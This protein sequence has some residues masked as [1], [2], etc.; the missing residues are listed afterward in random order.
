MASQSSNSRKGDKKIKEAVFE[1][2]DS[3]I[4][5]KTLQEYSEIITVGTTVE[6][7]KAPSRP[8][9]K[10]NVPEVKNSNATFVYNYF[11]RDERVRDESP[12]DLDRIIILDSSNSEEIFHRSKN[13]KLARYVKLKFSPPQVP[14]SL[15]EAINPQNNSGIDLSEQLSKIIIEGSMTN[16]IFTGVEILDTGREKNVYNMLNSALFFTE[17]KN[18]NQSNNA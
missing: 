17:L 7:S 6:E 12:N 8:V 16:Q 5:S 13:K 14:S 10:I 15:I 9:N 3:K 18:T 1:D 4:I 11:T 2:I